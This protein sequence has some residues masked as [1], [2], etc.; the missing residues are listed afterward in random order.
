MT[1]NKNIKIKHNI[2][3]LKHETSKKKQS[4]ARVTALLV[5]KRVLRLVKLVGDG[6]RVV[7]LGAGVCSVRLGIGGGAS[8]GASV[9]ETK[10]IENLVTLVLPVLNLVDRWN[11]H[12]SDCWCYGRLCDGLDP[13]ESRLRVTFGTQKRKLVKKKVTRNETQTCGE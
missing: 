11:W 8:V 9:N 2:R 4:G 12:S 13:C 5:V 1:Q 6:A 3:N 10:T 7:E